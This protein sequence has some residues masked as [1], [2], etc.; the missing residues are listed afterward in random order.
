M[1][2]T[3]NQPKPPGP[4]GIDSAASRRRDGSAVIIVIVLLGI[5]VTFTV[6]NTL[7]LQNLKQELRLIER[8]Q[9]KKYDAMPHVKAVTNA[10]PETANRGSS[11]GNVEAGSTGNADQHEPEPN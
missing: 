7:L 1:K 8:K 6:G 2:L 10:V 3:G 9:L 11:R 4:S 5:M